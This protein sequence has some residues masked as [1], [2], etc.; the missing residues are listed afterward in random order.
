[1]DATTELH[2]LTLLVDRSGSMEGPPLDYA[3]S[4]T[5]TAIQHL[6][7]ADHFALVMFDDH[8]QVVLPLQ[9][10]ESK[11]EWKDR[12]DA[13]RS[14]GLVRSTRTCSLTMKTTTRLLSRSMS[15]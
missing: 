11:A 5:R 6:R 7:K 14:G 9:S 10:A 4:A 15:S 1:M 12:V 2:A 13:I 8:A 3:L